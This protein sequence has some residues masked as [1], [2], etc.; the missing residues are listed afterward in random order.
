MTD[1]SHASCEANWDGFT[2][3]DTMAS[4][5]KDELYSVFEVENTVDQIEVRGRHSFNSVPVTQYII[6]WIQSSQTLMV[7]SITAFKSGP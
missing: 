2:K 6:L 5:P 3:M 4:N 1:A 7:F